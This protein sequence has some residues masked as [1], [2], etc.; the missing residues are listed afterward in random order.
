MTYRT[1]QGITRSLSE[2]FKPMQEIRFTNIIMLSMVKKLGLIA[3]NDKEEPTI[4]QI[5]KSIKLH[6]MAG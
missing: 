5:L 1:V 3:T 4:E 2:Y 6:I